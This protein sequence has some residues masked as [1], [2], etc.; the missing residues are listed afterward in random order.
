[1]ARTAHLGW[2]VVLAVGSAAELPAAAEDPETTPTAVTIAGNFQS[3][4]GCS[5]DWQPACA[6]THLVHDASD[7]VW[8]GSFDLPSGAWEYRVAI[9]DS[10]TESYGQHGDPAGDNIAF[11]LAGTTQVKFYYSHATHWA[12]D[13]IGSVIAAVPGSFQ[14][15]LGCPGDWDPACLRS[16][17]QDLDSDG[18]YRLTARGLP[19]G[20]Y[21]CKVAIDESW[22]ENYGLGGVPGGPNILFAVSPGYQVDFRYDAVTHLLTLTTALFADDFELRSFAAWS[23]AQP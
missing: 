12:T 5:G 16:W 7:L 23:T 3:E 22:A 14:S 9:D 13:D 18:I 20:N 6:A 8:R 15:E 17:L 4:V 21:E 2:I 11:A 1:M 10:W 19:T